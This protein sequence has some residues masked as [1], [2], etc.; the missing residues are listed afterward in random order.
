[1]KEAKIL[2]VVHLNL[3][4]VVLVLV[5]NVVH[6]V[7][8]VLVLVIYGVW[9]H[10]LCWVHR[11]AGHGVQVDHVGGGGPGELYVELGQLQEDLSES[12]GDL[13]DVLRVVGLHE[14]EVIVAYHHPQVKA[15]PFFVSALR[16]LQ[17]C[18]L[19]IHD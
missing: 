4:V 19:D 1:M 14:G 15:A 10:G 6:H 9:T 17:S 13:A 18:R 3:N 2:W 7:V 12:W 16:C 8:H 11:V 5:H